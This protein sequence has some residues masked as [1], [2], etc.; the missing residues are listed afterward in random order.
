MLLFLISATNEL[1]LKEIPNENTNEVA[2]TS[3]KDNFFHESGEIIDEILIPHEVDLCTNDLLV[4]YYN[5]S[6]QSK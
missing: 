2:T 6:I 3:I 5:K 1:T 4:Y